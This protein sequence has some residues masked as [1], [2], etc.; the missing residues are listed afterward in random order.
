MV[1]TFAFSS[2]NITTQAK[3]AEF[4][5]EALQE[6]VPENNVGFNVNNVSVEERSHRYVVDGSKNYPETR[7]SEFT[8]QVIGLNYSNYPDQISND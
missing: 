5:H 4:R 1:V 6:A 7:G 2:T 8:S 3:S